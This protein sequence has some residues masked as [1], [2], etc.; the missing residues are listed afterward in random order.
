VRVFCKTMRI[1]PKIVIDKTED[2]LLICLLILY[3]I[4]N[5]G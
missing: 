1:I 4:F 3:N 5:F 2:V